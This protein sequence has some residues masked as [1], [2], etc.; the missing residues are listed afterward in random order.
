MLTLRR[1]GG[2]TDPAFE[3]NHYLLTGTWK[4]IAWYHTG[5]QDIGRCCTRNESQGTGN[6]YAS[7]TLALKL[8]GDVTRSTKRGYQWP[9]KKD[10]CLS[11]NKKKVDLL[12]TYHRAGI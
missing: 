7:A 2:M 10:L 9:H 3:L 4:R 1:S 8:R 12:K 11:K 6:M 5:H